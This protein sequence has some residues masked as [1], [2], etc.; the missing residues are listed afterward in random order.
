MSVFK[1]LLVLV[2]PYWSWF[3]LNGVLSI[4]VTALSLLPPLYQKRIVDDVLVARDIAPLRG[5]ALTILGIYA[6]TQAIQIGSLYLRHVLGARF[7]RDMRVMLYKHLQSLSLDFF[8]RRQT[9]EIMSR[10]TNDVEVL[11]QFATHSVDFLVVDLLRAF[12][13]AGIL[14]SMNWRLALW[15]LVPVPFIAYGLRRFNQKVR[16][17]YRQVRDRLGDINAELQD[18]IAGIRVIQ[19]FTQEGRELG[20]FQA[21]NQEFYRMRCRSVAY[22]STFFPIMGFCSSVGTVLILYF[23]TQQT[24]AGALSLGG[25]LALSPIWPAFISRSTA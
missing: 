2:K 20:H 13:T 3:V 9:G 8:N 23:G 6:L 5:L 21:N 18:N 16:P 7:I 12:G 22:W 19:A 24:Y 15:A 10:M 14:F 4:A 1:R 17:I 11:E 25:L